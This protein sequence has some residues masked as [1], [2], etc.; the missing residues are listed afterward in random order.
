MFYT[1]IYNTTAPNIKGATSRLVCYTALFGVVTQRSLWGGWLAGSFC[2]LFALKNEKLFVKDKIMVCFTA[3][4]YAL[5]KRY[6]CVE[7]H[8][9]MTKNR[10]GCVADQ[11]N[12]SFV[13]NKCVSQALYHIIKT[14]V[15]KWTF[16]NCYDNKFKN[17]TWLQINLFLVC[18]SALLFVFGVSLT[19]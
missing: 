17:H 10:D 13:S 16:K 7:V 3:V 11:Q 19:F 15:Q 4:L 5:A 8:C 18:P 2:S 9:V 12:H 14:T 1:F 6:Y